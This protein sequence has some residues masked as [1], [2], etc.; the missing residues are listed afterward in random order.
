ME[1]IHNS[2]YY[3]NGRLVLIGPY[4]NHS[5]HNKFQFNYIISNSEMI[6]FDCEKGWPVSAKIIYKKLNKNGKWVLDQKF[7]T[8]KF[9]KNSFVLESESLGKVLTNL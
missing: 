3:Q 4:L 5:E 1:V 8:D 7:A 9:Y 6:Y 2:R